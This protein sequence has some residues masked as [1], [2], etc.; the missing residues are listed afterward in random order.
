LTSPPM[1]SVSGPTF[2]PNSIPMADEAVPS[3]KSHA[4]N[5][6]VVGSSSQRGRSSAGNSSHEPQGSA[7][8]AV[9][10]LALLGLSRRR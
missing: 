10:G 5:C 3:V 6:S 2:A 4:C 8:W 9:L 1:T 7:P